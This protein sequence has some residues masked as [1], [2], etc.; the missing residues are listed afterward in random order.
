MIQKIKND[1]KISVV[2]GKE[3]E[4]KGTSGYELISAY[5]VSTRQ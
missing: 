1:F 2:E 3:T 5:T 4:K